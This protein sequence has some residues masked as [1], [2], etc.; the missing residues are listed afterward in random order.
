MNLSFSHEV[1]L[2]S[3]LQATHLETPEVTLDSFAA[4]QLVGKLEQPVINANLEDIR[5]NIARYPGYESQINNVK[6]VS[7]AHATA[8]AP[9]L[10]WSTNL[11]NTPRDINASLGESLQ[12]SFDEIELGQRDSPASTA[13]WTAAIAVPLAAMT[14][15]ASYAMVELAATSERSH[16]TL[17]EAAA[18]SPFIALGAIALSYIGYTSAKFIRHTKVL[19]NPHGRAYRKRIEKARHVAAQLDPA[20]KVK[21]PEVSYK[22]SASG[23]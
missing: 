20:V 8:N 3:A 13:R 4:E 22:V 14:G 19:Q 17:T 12:R 21:Y 11:A 23:T 1:K 2:G 7:F 15:G 9:L 16:S 10:R 6:G 5:I 18:A